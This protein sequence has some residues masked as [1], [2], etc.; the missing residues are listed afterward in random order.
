MLCMR[1][2]DIKATGSV[3][4]QSLARETPAAT[5]KPARYRQRTAAAFVRRRTTAKGGALK[6]FALLRHAVLL[7]LCTEPARLFADNAGLEGEVTVQQLLVQFETMSARVLI[8][9]I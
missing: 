5:D 4:W 7:L 2:Q 6:H 1:H 8:D 9:V 3:Q